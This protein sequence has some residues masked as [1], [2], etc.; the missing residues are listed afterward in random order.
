[1]D[2]GQQF[3]LPA[4]V[5]LIDELTTELTGKYLVE[6]KVMQDT[7]DLVLTL[8]DNLQIQIFISSSGYESYNFS[9][10]KTQYIGMGSGDIA[11]VDKP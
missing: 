7:A 2:N 1:M 10:N 6:I 11:I 4:P 9:V 5:V 3:G 8:T